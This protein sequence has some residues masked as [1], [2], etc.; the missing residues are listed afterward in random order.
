MTSDAKRIVELRREI[1]RHN[2]LYYVEAATQISDREFDVLL[3]ELLDLE[4]TH[5]DLVTPDSPTQ[6]VGGEPI[7]G[8]KT[9]AHARRMMSIDNTYDRDELR[10]WYDRTLKGIKNVQSA[11]ADGQS[12]IADLTLNMT[13]VLEPKIDGVAVSLRYEKGRL[14][15]ALS[16]GDGQRGD[17]ITHNVRTI[18]AVP[19]TLNTQDAEPP[20]VLEVRG[21]IFMPDVEFQRINEQR[22][23]QGLDRLANPRNATAG[24]LKS[25]DPKVAAGR[26]LMF[27]AHG[28]GELSP[29][30]FISHHGFLEQLRA[31]GLPTNEH[32]TAVD[33]FNDAWAFIES[34]QG[35]RA[36]LG[37][38]T[39]G[40]VIKLDNLALQESLGATSKAPR[41]CIAYKYAAE[42]EQTVLIKVDWQVGKTGKLTPRAT[43]EPVLL[44]GTT[45][46]HATLH[47]MDEIT[48]KDIRLG[49]T[50]VIEKA[51]EIIPQVVRVVIENRPAS[52]K[53]ITPPTKCPSCDQPIEKLEDEVAHRCVN[54]ECPAQFREKLIWFVGRNQMDIDGLGEKAIIQ[55]ADAG[56]LKTFGDVYT[57]HTQRDALLELD[58]MGEK[59]ID[60]LLAG[61]EASKSRR[62]S[63]VLAGLGIR[64][65]G[66]SASAGLAQHFGDID[67]LTKADTETIAQVEDIGPIT[68]ESIHTFLN[69]DAGRHVIQELKDAG[70]D[71]TEE[72]TAP[73]PGAVDSPFAG[74][75]VVITGT[76][77]TFDRND[78]KAKLT[79]LGAKVTGSVSK[80]TDLLL[81][82]EKAGSKLTK[83][84]QLGVEVWDE[85]ALH[86]HL[87]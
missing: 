29:D 24:T 57:L 87:S 31:L 32:I 56:L 63:R 45:V 34:F 62:L 71:L 60:N 16:R 39:D 64:H 3:R 1:D 4:A 23:E 40:V 6:R 10:A 80:N 69:N 70:V 12:K 27:Y 22:D 43:M 47:N 36:K 21:E 68:A 79:R 59:K 76:F 85:A 14:V 42:Q 46:R 17:D 50:V 13:L 77:E 51:G 35:K 41:W 20:N 38:P 82:G 74:K 26:R 8:F 84:E 52:S 5:P 33:S 58:R 66:A 15:Q 44:A 7:E 48:R 72:K 19:L 49:D 30:T 9:L 73:P 37:Y 78:L 65:V 75:T 11:M 54:P 81:A 2:R 86:E 18:R 83:A 28:R 53:P 61:I 25:L 55:L 67:T